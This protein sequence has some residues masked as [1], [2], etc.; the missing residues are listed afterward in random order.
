MK[1]KPPVGR[2]YSLKN[3][4]MAVAERV[5]RP[6]ILKIDSAF[7]VQVPDEVALRFV[8]NDLPYRT[9]TALPGSLH[10]GIE[11]QAILE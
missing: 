10:F 1:A 4:G 2:L 3:L 6:T 9:K 7:A 11:P 5:C 8:D